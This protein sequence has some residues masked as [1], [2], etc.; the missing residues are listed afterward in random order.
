MNPTISSV[1]SE[2]VRM[3][4]SACPGVRGAGRVS[5]D[6]ILP[7]DTLCVECL[8]CVPRIRLSP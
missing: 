2:A 8:A 1:P 5:R 7:S 3:S 4:W 6:Q